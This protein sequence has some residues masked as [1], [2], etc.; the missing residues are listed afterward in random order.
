[1]PLA[2]K[3]AISFGC[4][5]VTS[6]VAMWYWSDGKGRPLQSSK[7]MAWLAANI[8]VMAVIS[9]AVGNLIPAAGDF[10][11]LKSA[12]LPATLAGS[13]SLED[14]PAVGSGSNPLAQL[15]ASVLELASWV[16]APLRTLLGR[17]MRQDM[18]AWVE[19][20]N[21][22]HR[23]YNSWTWQHLMSEARQ[24]HGSLCLYM[25]DE[26][27]SLG[28]LRGVYQLVTEGFDLPAGPDREKRLPVARTAYAELRRMA[29]IWGYDFTKP[30]DAQSGKGL[31]KSV[32]ALRPSKTDDPHTCGDDA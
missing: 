9:T 24:L 5:L 32:A 18:L 8:L 20:I 19:T 15:V 2:A 12:L 11:W 28:T 16:V 29:Y 6:A 3:L 21:G 4:A 27:T 30:A 1:M 13:K 23:P 26:K 22:K 7:S 25:A 10:F 17:Q 14:V 31:R